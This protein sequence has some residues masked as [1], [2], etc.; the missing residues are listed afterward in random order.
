MERETLI[1]I[2]IAKNIIMLVLINK[3]L[4]VEHHQY[5]GKI[6]DGLILQILVVGF[7]GLLD[8]GQIEDLQMMKDKLL[9]GKE[10]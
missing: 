3:K 2:I 8:I 6:K 5:F 1:K 4:N 10:L 9:D 7:S